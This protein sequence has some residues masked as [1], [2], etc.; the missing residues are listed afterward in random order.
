ML[1]KKYNG[2]RGIFIVLILIVIHSNGFGQSIYTNDM[3][4]VVGDV[5]QRFITK[6]ITTETEADNLLKGFT[7]MKVNGIRIPIFP[8]GWD[9]DENIMKY[10]F[11]QAKSQGFLIYA[12]PA[13]DSGARRIASGSL[14]SA[15]L[16]ATKNNATATATVINTVSQF[17]LDYPGLKWINPF[18]ED[19]RVDAG[20]TAA[21]INAIYSG[22]KSNMESFFANGDIPNVPEL[23]GPCAWGI[24]ASI[25]VM[26]NT[27]IGEYI[28]VAS[29]HNLGSNDSSWATFITAA[30]N[31]TT[32]GVANPLPVW[33]SEVNNSIGRDGS[34]TTRID[35]AIANKVDGLVIYNSGNNIFKGSGELTAL[36]EIY[37][38]KYLKEEVTPDLG[39]NLALDGTATQ[40]SVGY[41]G[42]T[43]DKA[44]DGITDGFLADN[45][46]SIISGND[47]PPYWEVD[48][49]G[50][51]EIGYIRV[52]NRTDNC[53]KNRLE[54]FTVYVRDDSGITTY[55][56]T[57]TSYPDPYVIMEVNKTGKIVRVEANTSGVALNIAEVEVYEKSELSVIENEFS[58]VAIYPNPVKDILTIMTPDTNFDNCSIYSSNGQ[59]IS[60]TNCKEN[61]NK[62]ELDFSEFSKGV[63]LLR[64]S[65]AK[66]SSTYKICKE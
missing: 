51:N 36:N 37:M 52:F 12:N 50:D 59:L 41:S 45:S 44:I 26:N 55:S 34:T 22:V 57:Y 16:I 5:K 35:A 11:E 63:Y 23:I 8:A 2:I 54:N 30:K 7:T 62:I 65:N 42:A 21:Q 39:V 29:S 9:Y 61:A 4:Y 60:T 66:S 56:K 64:L 15:D 13:Q 24:P 10:F 27:N 38:S 58:K 17:V 14:R 47:T 49:G 33:D 43:A 53:C 31:N 40:S 28:T 3:D 46:L 20:W 1:D 6:D 48:L 32:G 19:G 25:N 18:N